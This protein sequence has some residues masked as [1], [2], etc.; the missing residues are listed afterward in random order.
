MS[1][2]TTQSN[3]PA[4]AEDTGQLPTTIQPR[5]VIIGAGFGG[6]QAAK[7]LGEQPV[8][9]TV[10][11]R[12]NHHLFQP[13]LYQVAT[14]GLAPADISA[15]IRHALN[16]Q[17]NT[18]VLMGEVTGIDVEQQQVHLRGGDQTIPYDYLIV[19]TGASNNYFGHDDWQKLAPGLKSLNDSIDIRRKI[20]LAFEAAER[21][22]DSEARRAQLTFVL[23]GAGPTGV[24][25]AGAMAE[26]MRNAF[27]GDFRHIRPDEARIILVE[28]EARVMPHFPASITRRVQN[29]L[30][31]MGVE[32]LMG[33]HVKELDEHGVM[34]GDERVEARNVIWTAGVKASPA[35]KW[36][37]APTDHDGRVKVQRNL[38]IPGHSNV[39]VIGDTALAI[40]NNKPLPGVAPVAIQEGSYAAAIISDKV[41]GKG[42]PQPFRYHNKGTLA[43]VGRGFGVVN[44]GL[45]RFTGTFAWFVWLF[46]H[47]FFLI[48]APNRIIVFLQYAWTY[49]TFQKEERIIIPEGVLPPVE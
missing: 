16:K 24:E 37:G 44:I 22:Q 2:N 10:I 8:Q 19:A 23:V 14:A 47:L 39:F 9:I 32:L 7:D 36:L 27:Q 18:E 13:M 35:G 6:L 4:I 34:I 42:H 28:G 21:E 46:I 48:G 33:V 45:I 5:V 12:N 49:L 40:Q 41:A 25:L 3:K 43:T 29:K 30:K 20:L 1:V 26:L 38:T 31:Q 17:K 11:D 15:P